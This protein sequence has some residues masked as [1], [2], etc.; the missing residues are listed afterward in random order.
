MSE[1]ASP[2]EAEPIMAHEMAHAI[3]PNLFQNFTTDEA[4][5]D[6]PTWALEGFARWVEHQ[7][8]PGSAARGRAYVRQNR[9]R[10]APA[11]DHNLPPNAGFYSPDDKRTRFN[12]ELGAAL[13]GAIEQVGGNRRPSTSTSR[14]PTPAVPSPIPGYSSTVRSTS[15]ASTPTRSGRACPETMAGPPVARC[16]SLRAFAHAPPVYPP[17]PTTAE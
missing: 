8:E 3:G 4:I 14:S 1:I 6:Q 7:A 10:Y 11:G 17:T 5:T 13:F 9:S 2:A 15:A 16:G 12:Y